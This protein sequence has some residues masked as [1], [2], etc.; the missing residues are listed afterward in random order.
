MP[1]VNPE[2]LVALQHAAEGIRN[3]PRI[4]FTVLC[5]IRTDCYSQICVLAHVVC[6]HIL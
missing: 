1:V 4:M 6:I 5:R 2:R 3:V